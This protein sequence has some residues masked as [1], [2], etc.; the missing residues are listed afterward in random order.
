MVRNYSEAALSRRDVLLAL[1]TT[2]LPALAKINGIG[3][4]VCGAMDGFAKAEALALRVLGK[5]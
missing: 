5:F 1:A 3:I 4:G 2:A